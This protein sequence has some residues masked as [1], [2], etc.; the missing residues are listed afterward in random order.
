MNKIKNVWDLDV[1]KLAH[2]LTLSIYGITV[3]FPKTE[4][5]GLVSQMRR[6]ASSIPMNIAEGASRNSRAEYKRYVSIA[7]GSAGEIS[8]QVMLSRDLGY[9]TNDVC[10]QLSD[11]Y[12]RIGQML[13]RLSQ[14]LDS[15]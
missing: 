6:A 2:N 14:S 11:Q 1:F 8:Y 15:K 3:S 5:Y 4:I 10:N 12:N 7:K 13:T 9:I